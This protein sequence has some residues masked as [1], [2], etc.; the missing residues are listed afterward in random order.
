MMFACVFARATCSIARLL[1]SKDGWMSVCH[2]PVLCL[3]GKNI[4]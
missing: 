1:L 2:T 3:N 4:I